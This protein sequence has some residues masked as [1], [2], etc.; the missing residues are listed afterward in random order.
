MALQATGFTA[1]RP[2]EPGRDLGQFFRCPALLPRLLGMRAI[3]QQ[4]HVPS[5]LEGSA[6]RCII[7]GT[8]PQTSEN[9]Q[10]AIRKLVERD[11]GQRSQGEADDLRREDGVPFAPVS[12]DEAAFAS[13]ETRPTRLLATR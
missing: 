6:A 11:Q 12:A 3:A 8:L 5:G 2:Q 9:H 13:R 7:E 4:N 10:H 1:R